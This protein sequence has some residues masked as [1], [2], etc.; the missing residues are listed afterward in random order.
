[1]DNLLNL[2]SVQKAEIIFLVEN[3]AE[4]LIRSN[5]IANYY[6]NRPLLAEPGLSILIKLNGKNNY[7]LLDGGASNITS[8][9]FVSWC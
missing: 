2:G 9:C 7:I 1:M 4:M 5:K 3:K 6:T 8:Q